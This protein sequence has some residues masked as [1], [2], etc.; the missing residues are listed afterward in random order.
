M[1][2]ARYYCKGNEIEDFVQNPFELNA[3]NV[4][5]VGSTDTIFKV[6]EKI[7]GK[8]LSVD[9]VACGIEKTLTD[10]LLFEECF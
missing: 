7:C 5:F 3:L 1:V 9:I 10:Q 8:A 6:E 4:D 2:L